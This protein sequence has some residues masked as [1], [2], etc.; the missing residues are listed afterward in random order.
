M[1]FNEIYTPIFEKS[2]LVKPYERS[3]LQLLSVLS[4]NEEKDIINA[5]KH[6]AKTHSIMK[7]KKIIPLYAEHLHFLMTR[8]GWLITK[9]FKH[10]TFEQACFKKEFVTMNQNARKNAETPVERDFYK[11]MNNANFGIDC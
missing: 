7:E 5:F 9:I 3:V 4:R 2:K 11:L 1:L 10:Y 8:A 6:N